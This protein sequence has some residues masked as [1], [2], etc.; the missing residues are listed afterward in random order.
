M[1]TRKAKGAGE[2]IDALMEQA[3]KALQEGSYFEAERLSRDA[4]ERSHQADDFERMARIAL[5]L[6]E[7]RRQKRMLAVD[8]GRLKRLTDLPDDMALEPGAYLIEPMLV[9]AN[10]RDLRDRADAEE[11]PVLVVVREP[12]TQLRLWPIFMIGPGT[13]RT[14]VDPP[15]EEPDIPLPVE[16]VE[17]GSKSARELLAERRGT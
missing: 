17:Q 11:V 12:E 10:G 4:L 3:G 2:K 9:G 5:P 8:S 16:Y 1:S 7:A 15:D 14:T 13:V 6:Q